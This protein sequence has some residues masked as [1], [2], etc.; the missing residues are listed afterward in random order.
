MVD[1]RGL[2]RLQRGSMPSGTGPV[3]CVG[4]PTIQVEH[5]ACRGEGKV[6]RRQAGGRQQAS[7]VTS[8]QCIA[9][10]RIKNH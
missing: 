5:K 6:T 1:G 8:V 10:L 3:T 4:P 2:K 7:A 9:A